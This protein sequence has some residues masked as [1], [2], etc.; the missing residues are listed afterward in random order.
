MYADGQVRRAVVGEHAFPDRR[1]R[2]LGRRRGGIQRQSKLLLLSTRAGHGLRARHETE[3][4]EELAAGQLEAVAGTRNDQRLE[5]MCGELRALSQVADAGER[6][7]L[8]SL[9]DDSSR[10][11]C[12]DPVHVVDADANRAIFER[13]LR[14]ADVYVRRARLDSAP[15]TVADERR[16]WVEAHRLSVQE[17]AQELRRVVV[18]QPRRLVREQ[19]KSCGM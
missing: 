14:G 19:S 10:I 12:T 15:L 1:L 4:P 11:F 18:S 9:D 13:A 3:L 16:G 6:F 8:F 7:P 5:P 17:R 2:Q